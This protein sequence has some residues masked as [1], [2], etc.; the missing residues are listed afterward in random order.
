MNGGIAG[1]P[2]APSRGNRTDV[3]GTS[4]QRSAIRFGQIIQDN[5]NAAKD[6]AFLNVERR[7]HR[8]EISRAAAVDTS[9]ESAESSLAI[10]TEITREF[11]GD[12]QHR[13]W[14]QEVRGQLGQ[15]NTRIHGHA[16]V[17]DARQLGGYSE[18][19]TR[20]NRLEVDEG[21]GRGGGGGEG[22]GHLHPRKAVVSDAKER[23]REGYSPSS[24]ASARR[25]FPN[26]P[27]DLA[28]SPVHGALASTRL[29]PSQLMERV[30]HRSLSQLGAMDVLNVRT[31]TPRETGHGL[32]K[33]RH[34]IL[35]GQREHA[36]C[37]SLMGVAIGLS[38][39]IG[40][41]EACEF[42]DLIIA[43]LQA[44][45]APATAPATATALTLGSAPTSNVE[46][47]I[48]I[49]VESEEET[50]CEIINLNAAPDQASQASQKSQASQA[51]QAPATATATAPAT[52]T[53]LT[54][55]SAPTSNVERAIG[56]SVESEEETCCEII[57]LNA[58][59]DQAS[60]AS[61]ASQAPASAPALAPASAPASVLTSISASA[62]N[63]IYPPV[64]KRRRK[65]GER[66][67]G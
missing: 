23:A 51:S 17:R 42:I 38:E 43:P 13:S 4:F 11:H 36:V 55:G 29:S 47:A 56:I 32:E 63:I 12:S 14:L 37:S 1:V 53:A 9:Y 18:H 66:K 21:G 49:S 65:K 19:R 54:L 60:K 41:P 5:I 28:N 52:A 10:G 33:A 50:C 34:R 27:I 64:S 40:S 6:A 48:G 35:F 67:R 3:N 62:S 57:N 25:L 22:G 20:N 59:P 24:P 30:M 16:S 45:Q 44:S 8:G 26:P 15:P 2:T 58:A 46:R 31:R 39:N 61:Q 7:I